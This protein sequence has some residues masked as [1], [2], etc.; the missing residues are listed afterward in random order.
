MVGKA[1]L[2]STPPSLQQI[3]DMSRAGQPILM[4]TS[5]GADPS[6]EIRELAESTV[7]INKYFEVLNEFSF[8]IFVLNKSYNLY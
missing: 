1:S 3:L 5:S 8:I 7:G 4:L 6:Q 2:F